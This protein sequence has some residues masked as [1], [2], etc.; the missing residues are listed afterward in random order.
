MTPLDAVHAA[1]M[2]DPADDAARLRYYAR[3]ADDELFLLLAAEPEGDTFA[4]RVMDTDEGALILTFD[5][6][7]RLAAFTGAPAPYVALPGRVIAAALAGQGVAMGV[8]L[9]VAEA[10]FL[11]P[12]EALGW[13]AETLAAAPQATEARPELFLPPGALPPAL[14]AALEGKL[15]RARGLAAAAVLAGVRYAGGRQGH[16]L[17]FLGAAEEAQAALARA[18]GEALTFSGVEAGELDVTFLAPGDAAAPAI[19]RVGRMFDIAPRAEERPK[20][21]SAPGTD[22]DRPPRLK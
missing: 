8:N 5:T 1:M 17:A 21:P 19:L 16:M 12:P 20:A 6:E 22:P 11:V 14:I 10:A 13:L 15:D 7:E 9:G 2:A 3:L 18:V 4:P